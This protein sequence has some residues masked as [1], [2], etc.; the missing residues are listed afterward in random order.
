MS[1]RMRH[2]ARRSALIALCLFYL[3]VAVAVLA[4]GAA[5]AADY[6]MLL[7]AGNSGSSSFATATNPGG[8]FAF[9][10]QCGPAPDPAGNNAYLRIYENSTGTA[11][12][13][14]Y[15]SISWTVPPWIE[16][17]G[18][19]G[20]TREPSAFNDGWR[21]RFWAEDWAGGTNNILMQG[22]GAS[23]SG[24]NWTPTSTFASHLWPFSG[25]GSYRRFV[26]ELTCVRP[27]GC[28]RTNFNA[29]DANS[30]ALVLADVSPSQVALTATN[31]PFLGGQWVRGTQTVPYRWSDLGSGIRME[32][33]RIDGADRF[34]IDHQARGECDRDWSSANGEFARSFQPC[35]TATNIDRSYT[36]DTATLSDGAHTVRA[37][38]QDYAQWQGLYGTGGESCDQRTIH[39]DNTAPGKPADLHVTSANPERYLD[40]FGAGFSLPPNQG[41]PIAKVHYDVVDAA[42]KA[43]TPEKVLSATNPTALPNIEGPAKAADLSLR[44]WLEDQV[45]LSGPPA[46]APIPRDTKPPAAP[47]GL[48]VTAPD[49]PRSQDGFDLRWHDVLD[50]GSP[51]NAIHYQLLNDAGALIVPT[52]TIEGENLEAIPNLETP[53]Q[54]GNYTVRLWLEDAEGNVGVPA[55]APLAYECMRSDVSGATKLTSGLGEG[56]GAEEVVRQGAGSTL[57]GRLSGPA[58]GLANA[59]VCV[60]SRVITDGTR[61]FLGVALSGADG[62]YQFAVPPG[63]SREMTAVYRSGS[64]EVSSHA[65]L[66]T[67]VHPTFDAYRKVVYNKHSALFTGTIPG[68]HNNQV[69]VV[70]QV[71]RGKGWLAFHRYRTREGGRFTV[72]YR[73]TRTDVPTKYLMRA[74]VRAQGAYP[75]LEGNSDRLTL[76]VLPRAPDQRRR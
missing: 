34:V 61:E 41:S 67:I 28:D 48:Q 75:Y 46:I 76:I 15:G 29:V 30:I 32:R 58:G 40:H 22:T 1:P 55:S 64:R 53:Q 7:C 35:A 11:G 27:A 23:N 16:I 68:P 4:A 19:G 20:Y 60:F 71:K 9:E 25:F 43:A 36:F 12:L 3:C 50:S 51:I 24:I 62:S 56:G 59:P 6:K 65:T 45:G 72:G 21:G 70:L 74:Q 37:C 49:T 69:V 13:N 52:Q 26:F 14:A 54:R 33:V 42:G 66:Q 73:F 63:P 2:P 57:R 5:H 17:R 31:A 10:N 39:T 8:Q 18:G 38:T 44:L 47:Q